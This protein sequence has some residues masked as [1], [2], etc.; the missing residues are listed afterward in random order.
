MILKREQFLALLNEAKFASINQFCKAADLN[1][2]SV[3]RVL[4]GK[5]APGVRFIAATSYTL[6]TPIETFIRIEEI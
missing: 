6:N 4:S 1:P 2:G 5:V 3:S